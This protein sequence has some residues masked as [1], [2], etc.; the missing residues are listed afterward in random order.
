MQ[1]TLNCQKRQDQT[2]LSFSVFSFHD[3]EERAGARYDKI[4]QRREQR[5]FHVGAFN[6]K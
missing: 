2:I 4:A 5:L 6:V 3:G 1:S